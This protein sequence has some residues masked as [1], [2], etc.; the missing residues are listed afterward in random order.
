MSPAPASTARAVLRRVRDGLPVPNRWLRPWRMVRARRIAWTSTLPVSEHFGFDRG[1]PIDRYYIERFLERCSADV[2]GRVL[3][4]GDASYSQRFGAE[5][6]TH[7]DVLHVNPDAPGATIIGDLATAGVLPADAFDCIV[8]TQTLHLL[9]DMPAA[10]EQLH[11]AL[12]PGGVLLL[13][14]PGISQIDRAE[15]GSTWYWSLTQHSLGRLLGER[16]GAERVEVGVHGNVFAATAFLH[17]L[18]HEEV[19]RGKLD[20]VDPVY[21]VIVTG[22]AVKG[23]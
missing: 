5:R 6:I 3:E 13:T 18:A 11:A 2:R 14:T 10:V 21:P 8:L 12:K 22:R 16:F 17:G 15:W 1:T 9:Y 20:V 4:V 23:P 19:R 7:Q